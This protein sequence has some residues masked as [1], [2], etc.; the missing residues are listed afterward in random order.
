MEQ[1]V[2][3]LERQFGPVDLF[4]D[5]GYTKLKVAGLALTFLEAEKLCLGETTLE[6]LQKEAC[7]S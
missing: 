6:A 2:R 5:D 7:R 4:P 3:C 1:L